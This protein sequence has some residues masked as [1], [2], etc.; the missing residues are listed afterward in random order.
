MKPY[1]ALL[2]SDSYG[3]I[4]DL[5]VIKETNISFSA[6]FFGIFWFLYHKM[7]RESLF[8]LLNIATIFV[9]SK[10]FHINHIYLLLLFFIMVSLNA[11]NWYCDYLQTKHQYKYLGLFFAKN[12]FEAMQSVINSNHIYSSYQHHNFSDYSKNNFKFFLKK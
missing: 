9:V 2:K 7:W 8:Y 5:L 11:N 3:K 1:N 12:D 6:F 4:Q 10:I